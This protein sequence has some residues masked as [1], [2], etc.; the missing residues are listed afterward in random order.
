LSVTHLAV[1]WARKLSNRGTFR[2]RNYKAPVTEIQLPSN[3]AEC[4]RLRRVIC[5]LASHALRDPDAVADVEIAVGE[6][7]SNAIKYGALN[8]KVSVRVES[9][10]DCGLAIEMEYP[11]R[12]FDTTISYPPDPKSSTGGFGRFI[13]KQLTDSMEYSFKNGHTTLR[14]TK[15]RR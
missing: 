1:P 14:I 12:R 10:S 7:L 3:A 5:R 6:A 11:G 9:S 8:S 2:V 13:M 4:P 15:R